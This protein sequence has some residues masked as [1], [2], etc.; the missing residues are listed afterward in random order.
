M[1]EQEKLLKAAE[2]SRQLVKQTDDILSK[3]QKASKEVAKSLQAAAK[4]KSLWAKEDD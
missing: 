3:M 4:A 1:T 2:T